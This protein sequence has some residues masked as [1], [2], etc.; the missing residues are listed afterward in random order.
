MKILRWIGAAVAGALALAAMF[1]R[2]QRD[3]ARHRADNAEQEAQHQEQRAET[4]NRMEAAR[5]ESREAAVE[6]ERAQQEQKASGKRPRN[7]GSPVVNKRMR[8]DG[9]R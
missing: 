8:S 7:F 9:N 2:N 1:F 6:V 5:A 3:R 4:R